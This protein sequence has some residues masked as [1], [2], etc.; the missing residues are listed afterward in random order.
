MLLFTGFGECYCLLVLVSAL[1]Y[2]F[3]KCSCLLVCVNALV[4][5]FW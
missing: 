5:W 1:I 4:Y 3:G 2:W